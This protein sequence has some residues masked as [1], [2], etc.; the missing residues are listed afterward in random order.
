MKL[1]DVLNAAA[2]AQDLKL[3]STSPD[4]WNKVDKDGVKGLYKD[5]LVR[6][7]KLPPAAV[8]DLT[9]K[10]IRDG[11]KAANGDKTKLRDADYWKNL[12]KIDDVKVE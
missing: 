2:A 5:K 7:N 9:L 8:K 12:K 3:D 4:F 6:D 10:K 11:I 1:K